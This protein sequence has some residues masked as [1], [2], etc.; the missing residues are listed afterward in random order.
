MVSSAKAIH[1]FDKTEV[2][3]GN[4]ARL[5]QS[6]SR[7]EATADADHQ[8]VAAPRHKTSADA[9]NLPV[10]EP[11]HEAS[12]DAE[13]A[14]PSSAKSKNASRNQ[15]TLFQKKVKKAGC[16][17]VYDKVHFCTFCGAQLS[18]NIH[19]HLTNVHSDEKAVRDV[20]MLPK[21]SL[22]RKVKL[23]QLVNEGNFKHNITVMREGKGEIVVGRR[24]TSKAASDYTACGFCKKF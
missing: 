8:T 23:Q 12:D 9:D 5:A 1:C 11:R 6:S 10:A 4:C 18:G 24:C 13:Q 20:L 3:P 2:N 14:K 16:K 15:L 17:Q 19:R 7:Q 22:E 21:R